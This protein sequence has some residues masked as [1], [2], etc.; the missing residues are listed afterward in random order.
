MADHL[1]FGDID[2]EIDLQ[3]SG[4]LMKIEP[5]GKNGQWRVNVFADTEGP[6]GTPNPPPPKHLFIQVTEKKPIDVDL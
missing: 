1:D 6:C 4:A 3:N 5:T 2:F